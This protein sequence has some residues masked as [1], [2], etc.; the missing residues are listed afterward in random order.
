ML[1]KPLVGIAIGSV[2]R[3]GT[4]VFLEHTQPTSKQVASYLRDLDAL[5]SLPDMAEVIDRVERYNYLDFTIMAANSSEK[6]LSGG[7]EQFDEGLERLLS[8][9]PSN[10]VDWNVTLRTGNAWYDRLVI[11][12]NKP[13][14]FDRKVALDKLD[15]EWKTLT[16]NKKDTAKRF[17]AARTKPQE[18]GRLVGNMMAA[19]FLQ[20]A[21]ALQSAEDRSLQKYTNLRIAFALAGYKADNGDYPKSLDQLAPRYL[22]K[23]P[24]DLFSG[25]PL[26]YRRTKVG[27]MLNS[28]GVNGKDENGRRRS[29]DLSIRMPLPKPKS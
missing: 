16:K 28:V 9:V 2:A 12:M 4:L 15:A 8:G 27:Y 29:D 19:F 1:I 20:V 25:R 18:L 24:E 7:F 21:S 14:H 17:A 5:A 23:L 10:A 26:K 3:G 13:T 22:K 11:A 6:H